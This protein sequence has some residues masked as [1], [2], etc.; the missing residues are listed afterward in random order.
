MFSIA[1]LLDSAKAKAGI[2]SDYRLSK[3]I[4]INSSAVTNYR[5]GRS[6]PNEAILVAM[7]LAPLLFNPRLDAWELADDRR[8]D[9]RPG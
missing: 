8:R 5:S 3:L 9:Q 4:E 7:G 2:E 1:S 6:L